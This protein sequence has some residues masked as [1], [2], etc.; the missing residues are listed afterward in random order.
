MSLYKANMTKT[1]GIL[2]PLTFGYRVGTLLLFGLWFLY[3][4]ALIK[5]LS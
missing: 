5:M 2:N 4:V 1:I 3:I